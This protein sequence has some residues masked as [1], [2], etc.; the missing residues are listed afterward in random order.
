M[1]A[2]FGSYFLFVFLIKGLL[3]FFELKYLEARLE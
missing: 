3:K 1:V 2:L